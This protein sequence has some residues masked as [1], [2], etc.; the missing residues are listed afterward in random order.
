MVS[1][2]HHFKYAVA[3]LLLAVGFSTPLHADQA[4][5][6][7]LLSQLGS[8]EAPQ[9]GRIAAELQTE[10]SKSGSAA[11]DLL[12]RRGEDA[13][14]EGVPEV[15]AG[16]F[17]A[18]ID[19]AP[20]FAEAYVGRANAYY[21]LGY[22]GPALDDLRQALVLNPHHFVALRGFAVLLEEMGRPEAAL[23]VFHRAQA[24]YPADPGTMEAVER[25]ETMLGGRT[26]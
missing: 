20:D 7:D 25:L 4:R 1:S 5:I 24:V 9:A 15:A 12:L 2:S 16:H 23:E 8:A 3:A 21:L 17:T 18:A 14:E 19:H 11:M 26:L 6:D 13:L 22:V 10:W